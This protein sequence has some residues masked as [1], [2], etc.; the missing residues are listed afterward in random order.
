MNL[1][2]KLIMDEFR[3]KR[4]HLLTLEEVVVENLKTN[5]KSSGI[6]SME[7][8]HRV[9]GEHSLEGK[10]FRGGEKYQELS[11][12]TDLL[13]IRV[14]LYFADDVD[15]VGK[16]V[17]SIF[18]VD[19]DNSSDKR[20]LLDPK[21][22][23]YLSLHYICSLPEGAGYPEEITGI[24]FEIQ[25]RTVLQH[26]WAQ[27]EHDMGYKSQ[28]GVPRAITRQFA[29]LASLLELADEEFKRIRDQLT[30]Y[31]EEIR[32][33]IRN[34]NAENVMIDRISLSEYM[35]GSK[36]MRA[37]L[38]EMADIEGSEISEI[39]P[40]SYI[41]QLKWLGVV[42]IGQLQD[43]FDRNRQLALALA[44]R[45]LTGSE[46]DILSSNAA[47]RFI[48]RAELLTGPFTKE[49]AAEFLRLSI[50]S[51]ERANKQAERL[52]RMYEAIKPELAEVPAL[53]ETE[54]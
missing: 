53:P 35:I 33:Q 29:R 52:F 8:E 4:P 34:D 20:A 31:I 5:L 2:D 18:N 45:A 24:R 7:L 19:W 40:E 38:Q 41:D 21:T 10:L 27:I 15:K 6:S 9:K 39:D 32:E 1:K 12:I 25:I 3:K 13:G 51:E 17:E 23:G 11:D 43:M 30:I 47:L 36:K 46:L 28:F 49:Q 16:L 50:G 42:T 14:I 54:E 37:F 22:F 26:A 44:K 48:C